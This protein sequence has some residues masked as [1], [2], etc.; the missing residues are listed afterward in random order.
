L[1]KAPADPPCDVKRVQ[2]NLDFMRAERDM[3]RIRRDDAKSKDRS[4]CMRCGICGTHGASR[5]P[6]PGPTDVFVPLRAVHR[7]HPLTFHF[8]DCT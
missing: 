5:V 7:V 2:C 6:L 3:L 1:A 8:V 4:W